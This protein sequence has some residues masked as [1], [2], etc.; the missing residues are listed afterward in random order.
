MDPSS[1]SHNFGMHQRRSN[2]KIGSGI[3][4]RVP[5]RFSSGRRHRKGEF[6]PIDILSLRKRHSNVM[7]DDQRSTKEVSQQ[8]ASGAQ[9][10]VALIQPSFDDHDRSGK[11]LLEMRDGKGSS[12]IHRGGHKQNLSEHFQDATTLS[13]R[14]PSETGQKH[15][16]RY[17]GDL[18]NPAQ[19]HRRIDS[20]GKLTSVQRGKP[21]RRID[22][23]GLD[24]LTAAADFSRE[25]LEASSTGR[26]PWNKHPHPNL[27]R[28]PIETCATFDRTG[29][30]SAPPPHPTPP[31][32]A[33]PGG[34]HR[35]FSSGGFAHAVYY[36]HPPYPQS[37][38]PPH[39]YHY[40]HHQGSN[41]YVSHH[42]P[43]P[44]PHPPPPGG[45]PVQYARPHDQ[46]PYIKHHTPLQQPSLE[47]PSTEHLA[48]HASPTAASIGHK[49]STA[50]SNE[51][52]GPPAPPHFPRGGSTQGVQTYVTAIGAGETTRTLAP[53]PRSSPSAAGHHRKS[54]SFSNLGPLLWGMPA[55]TESIGSGGAH[56]RSTSS[57]L[58]F[59][60]ALDV[61]IKDNADAAFLRNL[62]ETTGT[63]AA[64]YDAAS[65]QETTEPPV[66]KQPCTAPVSAES[67]LMAGGT[68]KR[69]R[70]KC[71]IEGCENRVVQGGLCI[72]HGAKRK[73]CKYPGCNK[74]VKKAGLCSTHGPARK[75]CDIDGCS[76][77]AV[78][79]GRCIAHGAKK[80][81][82]SVDQCTK[83]A[84]L[85]GM[86]KKHHDQNEADE[87]HICTI[88]EPKKSRPSK[89]LKKPGHTRGL[90]IFQEISADAVCDL[91]QPETTKQSTEKSTPEAENALSS[92]AKKTVSHHHHR[93]TASQLLVDIV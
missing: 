84:I 58:S 16:R 62:H 24:A 45:Y 70:R 68:S 23:S 42:G 6:E 38:Y 87:K 22:S 25:E 72:S 13:N 29:H 88:A 85:S 30:G 74:H 33:A 89:G 46:D 18:S 75:R 36:P 44:P 43:P 76:K 64:G 59:L 21:H 8:E 91:L 9:V 40:P 92:S 80:K 2:R 7:G 77:V 51:A 56:H 35:H 83:Q 1:F 28:S 41:A 19:A 5:N 82:C 65:L 71:N 34:H 86:C 48:H 26:M 15:R 78:Q 10:D 37:P 50:K 39:A 55:Q 93:S 69:V 31:Q 66:M 3:F 53:G 17:S 27:R 11:K 90:S 73:L 32:L 81:L 79:G 57:S 49:Q 61:N 47:R 54:S 63:R 60:R 12:P 20:L 67:K 14:K 4:S 52:M